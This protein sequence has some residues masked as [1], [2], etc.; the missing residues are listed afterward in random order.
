MRSR[1]RQRLAD[2]F[3][4]WPSRPVVQGFL[5]L[6]I[7]IE[8]PNQLFSFKGVI[9]VFFALNAGEIAV[10]Q[11]ISSKSFAPSVRRRTEDRLG[12]ARIIFV[13]AIGED[14]NRRFG[15][16]ADGA[17]AEPSVKIRFQYSTSVIS[18]DSFPSVT[19]MLDGHLG[20]STLGSTVQR[21]EILGAGTRTTDRSF[22]MAGPHDMRGS[23]MFQ[24]RR[25]QATSALASRFDHADFIEVMGVRQLQ[26]LV[27]PQRAH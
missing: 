24:A 19:R 5:Q 26:S 23:A 4:K 15:P 8:L 12:K 27:R 9:V 21:M 22:G 20:R 14:L 1:N 11:K 25:R 13:E 18:S 10:A 3:E 2:F 7:L 6:R 16:R 17:R